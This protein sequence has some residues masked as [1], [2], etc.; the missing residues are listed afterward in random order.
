MFYLLTI[1][2]ALQRV[3]RFTRHLLHL[4]FL[5]NKQGSSF[6]LLKVFLINSVCIIAGLAPQAV[7]LD[8]EFSSDCGVGVGVGY[9]V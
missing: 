9:E 5:L 7:V 8:F 3:I 2:S 1:N 6:V 4:S